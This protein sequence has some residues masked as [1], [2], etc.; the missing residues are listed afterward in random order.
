[1]IER[2]KSIAALITTTGEQIAS[3]QSA[4]ETYRQIAE[5]YPDAERIRIYDSA[6]GGTIEAFASDLR[7]EEADQ[8]DVYSVME[9][10]FNWPTAAPNVIYRELVDSAGNKHRMYVRQRVDICAAFDIYNG[11]ADT[12]SGSVRP[13][14]A[15]CARMTFDRAAAN[16]ERLTAEVK[17]TLKAEAE[18]SKKAGTQDLIA[19]LAPSP[20]AGDSGISFG[21]GSTPAAKA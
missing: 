10:R 4:L 14:L 19:N 8:V 6:R 15:A 1:M 9:S 21:T 20:N 11:A 17:E 12:E 18:K 2:D 16:M 5:Q 13:T 3:S 7:T